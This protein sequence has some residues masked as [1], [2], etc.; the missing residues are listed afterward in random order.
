MDGRLLSHVNLIEFLLYQNRFVGT[1]IVLKNGSE[2]IDTDFLDVQEYLRNQTG[3]IAMLNKRKILYRN[4][5]LAK[6][7][8]LALP[9]QKEGIF[10]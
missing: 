8:Y 4:R 5:I 9:M 1:R 3:F 10:S 2:Q 7:E 6:D